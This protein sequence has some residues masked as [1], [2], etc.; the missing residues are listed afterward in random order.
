[1]SDHIVDLA[2]ETN[3]HRCVSSSRLHRAFRELFGDYDSSMSYPRIDLSMSMDYVTTAP[4]AAPTTKA[5]TPT[6]AP[7]DGPD[8][9]TPTAAPTG[10]EGVIEQD[11]ADSQA[12]ASEQAQTSGGGGVDPGK[13]ALIVILVVAAATVVGGLVARKVYKSRTSNSSVSDS[14]LEHQAAM[15]LDGGDTAGNGGVPSL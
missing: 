3:T 10:L 14:S 8:I 2:N 4:N 9:T 13:T 15:N 1:M 7:T 12:A 5:A 11:T 6:K